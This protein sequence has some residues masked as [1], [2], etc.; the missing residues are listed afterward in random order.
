MQV[1]FTSED[2]VYIE[3]ELDEYDILYIRAER[4]YQNNKNRVKDEFLL[5][6]QYRRNRIRAI[7]AAQLQE[8]RV[9]QELLAA[10]ESWENIQGNLNDNWHRSIFWPGKQLSFPRETG[11]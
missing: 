8:D 1:D 5:S 3:S 10:S 11:V 9:S 6:L 7:V 4:E 2:L